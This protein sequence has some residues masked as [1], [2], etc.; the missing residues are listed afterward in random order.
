MRILLL[1][2]ALLASA[3]TGAAES[4]RFAVLSLVGDK[5]LV[6]Q[7]SAA[8]G[9]QADQGLQAYVHLDDNSL[10]KTMLQSVDAA[11]KTF[12]RTISPILLVAKD[13]TLYSAQSELLATN[14]SS[15]LLLDK[16]GP[17]LRGSGSTHLILV[18]KLRS[19]AR[20]RQLKDAFLGGGQLEGLGFYVDSGRS[21][22]TATPDKPGLGGTP[23]L[24]PF[25]YYKME[26][27]DLAKGEIVRKEEITASRVFSDPASA[28]PWAALSNAEK[29]AQLQDIIRRETAKAVPILLGRPRIN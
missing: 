25:A 24:G 20:V 22:P 5:L 2:L 28:N 14:R 21:S 4:R 3:A 11:L 13:T 27:I 10:D 8:G 18:T 7:Y 12:D 26:L 16:I 29:I 23:V 1:F 17:M 19:D 9:F 6:A 15:T